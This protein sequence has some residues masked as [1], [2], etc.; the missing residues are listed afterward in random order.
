MSR[1]G[2]RTVEMSFFKMSRKSRLSRC[3]FSNCRENL[4]CRDVLFQTVEIETLDWDLDKNREISII[5]VVETVETWF[6]NSR[7][8]L[9]C[10]DVVFQTVEKISTVETDFFLC[11]DRESRSR[12]CRDK[13]RPPR[14][15]IILHLKKMKEW[16]I[17]ADTWEWLPNPNARLRDSPR[18][19]SSFW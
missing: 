9:D 6:L 17:R 10:R 15:L 4:D 7:E 16:Q 12:P 1:L 3:R 11:R 14:L 5:R 13:S 19:K 8:N 18:R 2:F